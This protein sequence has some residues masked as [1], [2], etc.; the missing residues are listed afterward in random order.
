MGFPMASNLRKKI[1]RESTLYVNDI[2]Q[3]A[4]ERFVLEHE[5][6]GPVKVLPNAKA[7]TEHSVIALNI[8]N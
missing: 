5:S 3:A 7:I 1:P 8:G 6:Y 2:D 4:V